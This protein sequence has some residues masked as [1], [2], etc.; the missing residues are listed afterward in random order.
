MENKK[1]KIFTWSGVKD[2]KFNHAKVAGMY[3]TEFEQWELDYTVR[4]EQTPS[5]YANET[6]LG[7]EWKVSTR[8]SINSQ[9]NKGHKDISIEGLHAMAN[10]F[11]LMRWV[12]Y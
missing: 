8:A 4:A 1:W 12:Y 5:T 10:W 9:V 11:N 6:V 7:A 3:S 2:S